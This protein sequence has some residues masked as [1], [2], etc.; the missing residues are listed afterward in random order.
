[1]LNSIK[2]AWL[3]L[4]HGLLLVALFTSNFL[5]KI[6]ATLSTGMFTPTEFTE[7]YYNLLAYH[8]RID[9][10]MQADS[11][12]FIGD[13][14]TQGLNVAAV[15]E[16]TINYGIGGDTSKGVIQRIPRYASLATASVIVME[17][18][19]NDLKWRSDAEILENY[20]QI[21]AQLPADIPVIFNAVFPVDELALSVRLNS[22]IQSLNAQLRT[23]VST[24]NHSYFVDLTPQFASAEG[25]LAANYHIGDGIHL[26]RSGYALWIKTLRNTIQ[27]IQQRQDS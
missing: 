23:L 19:F 22:R 8:T 24:R 10:S 11:V 6:D 9:S 26:N 4:V 5:Q 12:I 16:N 27:R 25:N 15:A 18:G 14:H 13:S 17:I 3:T 21:L 20:R 7:Y 2:I 1:M